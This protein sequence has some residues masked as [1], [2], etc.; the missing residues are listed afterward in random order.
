MLDE[1][2]RKVAETNAN[3]EMVQFAYKP[4]G[5]LLTLTDRKGQG[6][7]WGYDEYGRVTNKVDD[8]ENEV[9]RCT[10]PAKN[11]QVHGTGVMLGTGVSPADSHVLA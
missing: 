1:L 8:A 6:T 11:N 9:F 3:G 5:D 2:G 4:A 10:Q 7:T